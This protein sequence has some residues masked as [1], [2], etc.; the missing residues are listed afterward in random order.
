MKEKTVNEGKKE[1]KNGDKNTRS[2]FLWN[3]PMRKGLASLSLQQQWLNF[4]L[5]F[6]VGRKVVSANA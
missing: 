6:L 3:K 1:K 5:W 2:T 4:Q